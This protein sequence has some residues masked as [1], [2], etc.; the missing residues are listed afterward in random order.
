M[1]FE[2]IS[3]FITIFSFFFC[4]FLLAME[5]FNCATHTLI[6]RFSSYLWFRFE[7]FVTPFIPPMNRRWVELCIDTKHFFVL[8]SFLFI[9][10]RSG[11]NFFLFLVFVFLHQ[12][13]ENDTPT[14]QFYDIIAISEWMNLI[15]Y[16]L[17]CRTKANELSC[18]LHFS[19]EW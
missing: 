8:I 3:I 6:H 15:W 2:F 18:Y 7:S 4:D 17:S 19:F 1:P 11:N 12:I 16:F 9:S 10:I 13:N 14:T 5:I